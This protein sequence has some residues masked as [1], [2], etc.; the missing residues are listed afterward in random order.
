MDIKDTRGQ[1]TEKSP[2]ILLGT[3]HDCIRMKLFMQ[4]IPMR[5]LEK[6]ELRFFIIIVISNRK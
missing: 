5:T 3:L 2:N 6:D 1:K 4:K